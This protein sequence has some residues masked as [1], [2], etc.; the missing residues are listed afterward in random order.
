MLSTSKYEKLVLLGT[1]EFQRM[2]DTVCETPAEKP[3]RLTGVT[4][5]AMDEDIEIDVSDHAEEAN[6]LRV[7]M[8]AE[9]QQELLLSEARE[10]L[11]NHAILSN[12]K[13]KAERAK[14]GK[15]RI[16]IEALRKSF[17]H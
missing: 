11:R 2:T 8:T 9:R 4:R 13:R 15:S 16:P 17:G 10:T 12:K 1:V 5:G 6:S 14:H 7:H 3:A